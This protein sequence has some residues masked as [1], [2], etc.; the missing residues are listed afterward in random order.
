M[1]APWPASNGNPCFALLRAL[2]LTS[3]HNAFVGSE[4]FSDVQHLN[5]APKPGASVFWPRQVEQRYGI[6]PQTRWRWEKEGRLPPRDV[7]LGGK[8]GWRVD[9]LAAAEK[10]AA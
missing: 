8:T 6:S 9:T 3:R 7:N 2:Y 1:H 10:T 5:S 4:R